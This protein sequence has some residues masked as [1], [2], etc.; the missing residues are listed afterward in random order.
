[1]IDAG[2]PPLREV[3]WKFRKGAKEVLNMTTAQVLDMRGGGWDD[4]FIPIGIAQTIDLTTQAVSA[5]GT[6]E[7][8]LHIRDVTPIE[9]PDASSPA[10]EGA[11]DWTGT[12]KVDPTGVIQEFLFVPAPGSKLKAASLDALKYLLRWT[13][14]PVPAEPIGVG[15]K[16]TVDQVVHEH[17][18]AITEQMSIELVERAG[19]NIVLRVEIKE[20]GSRRS[21]ITGTPQEIT[22]NTDAQVLAKLSRT[23]LAPRSSALDVLMIQTVETTAEDGSPTKLK[24]TIDRTIKMQSK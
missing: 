13:F 10:I 16:W 9:T 18:M 8:A 24:M 2:K 17:Q 5:E 3:R 19:S 22:I 20:S 23:K 12:Y 7:V 11:K 21:D 15:A 4:R 14:F 1:L 6:A